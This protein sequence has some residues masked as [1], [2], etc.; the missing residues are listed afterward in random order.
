[1]DSVRTA[2]PPVTGLSTAEAERRRAAG[3]GNDVEIRAGRTYGRIVRDNVFN[4]I[5]N[6]FYFLGILL[7]ILGKPLD[8]FAVVFVIGANTVISLFQEIRAKRVMDKMAILLRPKADVLRDGQVVEIDPSQVVLGDVLRLEPGDQVVVDGP[9][10][11]E[12]R[13]EVDESLLTGESDLVTKHPGDDLMSGSFCMTGGGYYEAAQVGLDSF[14]NKLTAKATAY[15]RELTPLQR[16]VVQIV[17][18]LLIVVI[19]FEALVWIRNVIGGVPFVESVRMSTVILALI[20]N[21]LVLSI[22][23][24][25]ALGAVRLLG[26]DVLVQQFNAVESLSNVDVLCTDKTGTLTS[27]V[28]TFEELAGLGADDA[29]AARLLGAF[30]ASTTDANRTIEALRTAFTAERLPAAHEAFFSS[31]RKWSGLAFAD[32]EARGT[33]V[34]GAPEIL[35]PALGADA[36]WRGRADEWAARGLR[37]VMFAGRGEPTAFGADPDAPPVLPADLEPLALICFSDELRPGVRGTLEEFSEAGIDVKIISGD[38]PK[39]V[40]ALAT[41]AGVHSLRR[42]EGLDSY[43]D[44]VASPGASAPTTAGDADPAAEAGPGTGGDGSGEADAA[45]PPERALVAVSGAELAE[46]S[47]EDFAARADEAGI[48]GRV[49]PEQ[50][51]D[52]V[53]AL[54]DRGR[55]VAMIGDGVNDVIALKQANVAV[56]MQGGSQAARSVGDLI[57]MK[58]TFAPLPFAF[59]EGQRIINGMNDILRIFMVRIGFKALMIAIIMS[60]GGFPFA[61]RQSALLSFFGAT[62]PAIAFALWAQPGPTPKVGLFKLLARFVLPTV[63]F[64]AGIGTAVYL[65]WAIPAEHA[66]TTVAGT[67]EKELAESGYPPAMT[68]LT[69]FACLAAVFLILLIVPPNKWW[70]AARPWCATTRACSASWP[71]CSP[72]W[73]SSSPCRSCARCSSSPHCHGGSTSCCWGSRSPGVSSACSCG[74]RTCSTAGW[75]R[76]RTRG[77][78]ARRRRPKPPR[79]PADARRA[80]PTGTSAPAGTPGRPAAGRGRCGGRAVRSPRARRTPAPRRPHRPAR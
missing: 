62:V 71:S 72:A 53:E 55:Y 64:M 7:L 76:R 38:N 77:T 4:F 33:Y 5:N 48:F 75:A 14:A 66:V 39:T 19:V 45:A 23:L 57:L 52:L 46:L 44:M 36:E 12:G 21:G 27:G 17:R 60:V 58:D 65:V 15:K 56:A 37:V 13:M 18:I 70:A 3:Q 43:C 35:A 74:R 8:A 41:Q 9:M 49:T 22:A 50:K 69:I 11:G 30:A 78:Y 20:P 24:T 28:V 1:M 68:A 80:R 54:R 29:R 63:L 61:P 31:E 79:R 10:V 67:T 2:A 40:V 42:R 6:L 51:Q 16:Q 59:R 32:G 26:K 25:Y 34:L 47:P 73:C